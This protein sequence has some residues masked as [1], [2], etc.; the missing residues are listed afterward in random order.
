MKSGLTKKIIGVFGILVSIAAL[1]YLSRKIDF[2]E[3]ISL[4]KEVP[5]YYFV[6]LPVVYLTTFFVRAWRW[7]LMLSNF[8]GIKYTEYL[9]GVVVGFAGNNVIPARGG[10]ILRMAFFSKRTQL[11]RVTSLSSVLTEK[12]LDGVSLLLILSL[13]VL[14]T[15]QGVFEKEWFSQ[16]FYLVVAVFGVA[17]IGLVVVRVFGQPIISFLDGKEHKLF[18]LAGGITDKIYHAL[19]FIKP[20]FN[21]LLIIVS[22]LLTWLIEGGMFVIACM[23]FD[24][25]TNWLV[26]GYVCLSVVNFG[27]LVPSSPGYVGVFQGMTILALS[28]FGIPEEL[29]L[30]VGILV[31]ICQFVPITIWGAVIIFQSS[32]KSVVGEE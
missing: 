32:I 10:E 23:A 26:A 16:M 30:S 3:A 22:G 27:L 20:D 5:A 13:A 19:Y 2:S 12:I 4:L 24:L 6:L 29:S 17:V 11:N 9:K 15:G 18:K 8:S 25:P 14:W 7:K 1:V 28:L 31:H 21:S